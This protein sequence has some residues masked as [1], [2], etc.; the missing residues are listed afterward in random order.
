MAASS[1]ALR[2]SHRHH[3][4]R[5]PTRY[6]R[7]RA[8][9]QGATGAAPLTTCRGASLAALPAPCFGGHRAER[10]HDVVGVAALPRLAVAQPM[11]ATAPGG[12][13]LDE[14]AALRAE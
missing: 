8:A 4:P 11:A 7:R 12:V 13:L 6:A 2:S 1:P 9:P 14:W 3:G 5:P 10:W